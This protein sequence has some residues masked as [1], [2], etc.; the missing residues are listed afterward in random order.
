MQRELQLQRLQS[1]I[2]TEV[3]TKHILAERMRGE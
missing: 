3:F 1:R 2:I